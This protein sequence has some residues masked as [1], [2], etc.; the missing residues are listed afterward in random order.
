V[1]IDKLLNVT[2]NQVLLWGPHET[3]FML[4]HKQF[5]GDVTPV[6]ALSAGEVTRLVVLD[7]K[8]DS[9]TTCSFTGGAE[10]TVLSTLNTQTVGKQVQN[11]L[12]DV[13]ETEHYKARRLV[14]LNQLQ[15]LQILKNYLH[16]VTSENVMDKTFSELIDIAF[17]NRTVRI[18]N[19]VMLKFP[20]D[21]RFDD[22]YK[23]R[24]TPWHALRRQLNFTKRTHMCSSVQDLLDL[25][26]QFQYDWRPHIKKPIQATRV[27]KNKNGG[28]LLV[29]VET[30]PGPDLAVTIEPT[31]Y[32][33]T[34]S[35]EEYE[36]KYDQPQSSPIETTTNSSDDK[37]I[38]EIVQNLQETPEPSWV[39]QKYNPTIEKQNRYSKF[40]SAGFTDGEI[41]D[42][43]TMREKREKYCS[44]QNKIK[45]NIQNYVDKMKDDYNQTK[46]LPVKYDAAKMKESYSEVAKTK[47]LITIHQ[48]IKQSDSIYVVNET[49]TM[50]M[51]DNMENRK[52]QFK[53]Q[54]YPIPKTYCNMWERF[55]TD[56]DLNLDSKVV[57]TWTSQVRLFNNDTLEVELPTTIVDEMMP[58][59]LTHDL[60]SFGSTFTTAQYK[61]TSLIKDLALSSEMS[62]NTLMWAPYLAYCAVKPQKQQLK[63]LYTE[64]F[65]TPQ[66]FI[67]W[68]TMILVVIYFMYQSIYDFTPSAPQWQLFKETA[69]FTNIFNYPIPAVI[70]KNALVVYPTIAMLY[71]AGATE[72]FVNTVKQSLYINTE[73]VDCFLHP[74][75]AYNPFYVCA[76]TV[77]PYFNLNYLKINLIINWINWFYYTN[78]NLLF[79]IIFCFVI[80]CLIKLRMKNFLSTILEQFTLNIIKNHFPILGII[81]HVCILAYELYKTKHLSKLLHFT[82]MC[83]KLPWLNLFLHMTYNFFGL[84]LDVFNI[85]YN[86]NCHLRNPTE[87]KAKTQVKDLGTNEKKLGKFDQVRPVQY[88]FGL[89]TEQ[90]RPV[91]YAP[92][93]LNELQALNARVV[94]PTKPINQ[95]LMSKFI[96]FAKKHHK[97][98]FGSTKVVPHSFEQ[99]IS[100]S[101]AKP[102]VIKILKKTNEELKSIGVTSKSRLTKKQCHK[103]ST[104]KSFVKVENLT[105]RTPMGRKHKAPR[106]IQGAQPEFICLV[107]PAIQAIQC[108]VKTI[109]T[110]KNFI[111]FTSGLTQA[112]AAACIADLEEIRTLLEDDVGKWDASVCAELMEYE[113]WLTEKLLSGN[114]IAISQLMRYNIKTHGVTSNGWY[115]KS[116]DGRKS[117][118]PYTSLYNSVLNGLIHFFIF[119]ECVKEHEPNKSFRQITKMIKMIVQGDDNVVSHIKLPYVIPWKEKMSQFGFDAEAQTKVLLDIEFCSNNLYETDKGILFGP[120]PGKVLSKIGYFVQP[121]NVPVPQ[122]MRGVALG[123]KQTCS[124]IPPI[125]AY[126]NRVLQLTQ[127]VEPTD[128]MLEDWRLK[129]V[130]ANATPKT[131]ITLINK[132]GWDFEKQQQWEQ[133]LSSW[134]FGEPLH[135]VALNYMMDCDTSG[136][137]LY[138]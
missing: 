25:A 93:K 18:A 75:Y 114:H 77:L 89:N 134:K 63:S 118:D 131:Y 97:H 116:P 85:Y 91:V 73:Y 123:L 1:Y 41:S 95:P 29:G 50:N 84:E 108:Y 40:K 31:E 98:F 133:Q 36:T 101:N 48:P 88:C 15:K 44:I 105:F 135:N 10:Q 110:K 22:K 138:Q 72:T 39:H 26:N 64:S 130:T 126:L 83:P 78:L 96:L 16:L 28:V 119:F 74:I 35:E 27:C 120:K 54:K 57:P 76:P 21:F 112:E 7:E 100:M 65:L 30:N 59:W 45:R 46:Q 70:G 47:E 79:N 58:F 94:V 82:I 67:M 66:M 32:Q 34:V 12:S 3:I 128:L 99:Y 2:F 38:L 102:G 111:T 122:L 68:I 90:Y 6:S 33:T 125:D 107:G 115:Y 37:I 87:F 17:V 52:V 4:S 60:D 80:I 113:V 14:G 5:S 61:C 129:G 43:E 62:T 8:A 132:Y 109:W 53:T 124:F 127:G 92:N 121:P 104:R 137:Q 11:L 117:G 106:L 81:V 71:V 42:S 86:S 13:T 9:N 55:F 19:C 49:A 103:W 20:V 51:L 23:G 69:M 136:P 24:R 56:K